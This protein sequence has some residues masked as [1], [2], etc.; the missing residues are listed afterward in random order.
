MG[1]QPCHNSNWL[2][3]C[4]VD[5][6]DVTSASTKDTLTVAFFNCH[7]SDRYHAFLFANRKAFRFV[8]LTLLSV[9]FL[10]RRS[11]IGKQTVVTL[12][13]P[14]VAFA[15]SKDNLFPGSIDA[16]NFA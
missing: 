13:S 11:L 16:N 10:T 4:H 12:V 6:V 15:S 8:V 5:V 7:A 2:L 14:N 9:F 3:V 1:S